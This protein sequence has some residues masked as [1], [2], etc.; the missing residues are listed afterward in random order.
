MP[1]P[2]H[3]RLHSVNLIGQRRYL[4][5]RRLL[6][7]HGALFRLGASNPRIVQLLLKRLCSGRKV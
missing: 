7:G 2:G 5:L 1:G 3:I 6:I 4:R